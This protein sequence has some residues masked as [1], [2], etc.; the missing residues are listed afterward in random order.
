[1]DIFSKK[2][3]AL[4][5]FAAKLFSECTVRIVAPVLLLIL[6]AQWLIGKYQLGWWVNALAFALGAVFTASDLRKKAIAWGKEYEDL[7]KLQK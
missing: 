6:I 5:L 1:M 4:Y 2:D 7:L 3:R